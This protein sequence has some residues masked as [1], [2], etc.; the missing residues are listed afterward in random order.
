MATGFPGLT[1]EEM[2][3]D[4]AALRLVQ[5]PE[6]FDVLVTTN[7]F[8]DILSDEAAGLVGG[9]GLAPS[10][11]TGETNGIFEPVHGSA[12]DI[13]GQGIAN[14]IAAILASA[15][16]LDFLGQ[17]D[18]AGA[19]RGAVETVLAEGPRPRDLGGLA[20]TRQITAGIVQALRGLH[21][22]R[23]GGRQ[24]PESVSSVQR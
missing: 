9:L 6:H 23:M 8:G 2:L 4:T 21:P 3:V 13:A 22:Q 24:M 10:G 18:A 20:T 11:N 7:L 12:P 16:M 15:M 1:V 19:V 17:K 14:P 5:T